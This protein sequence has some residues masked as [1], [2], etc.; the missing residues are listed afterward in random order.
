ML[1]TTQISILMINPAIAQ[2]VGH[3]MNKLNML[4][5]QHLDGNIAAPMLSL[6]MLEHHPVWNRRMARRHQRIQHVRNVF[7]APLASISANNQINR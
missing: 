4:N 6:Q 1:T 7:G 3:L 2:C 5:N